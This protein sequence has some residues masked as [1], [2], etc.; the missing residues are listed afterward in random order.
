M[1]RTLERTIFIYEALINLT[2]LPEIPPYPYEAYLKTYQ[3]KKLLF[4]KQPLTT[5]QKHLP[6]VYQWSDCMVRYR[7]SWLILF[8][9]CRTTWLDY[10]HRW[11]LWY[12]GHWVSVYFCGFYRRVL[13]RVASRNVRKVGGFSLSTCIFVAM[14]VYKI[15]FLIKRMKVH[16]CFMDRRCRRFCWGVV[17]VCVG[18]IINVFSPMDMRDGCDKWGMFFT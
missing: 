5:F 11:R 1:L 14:I 10:R 9:W 13:R 12:R 15:F 4:S 2:S 16:G 7:F 18:V 17:C 8:D 3:F 6:I